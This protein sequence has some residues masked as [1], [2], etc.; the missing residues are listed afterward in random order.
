[1][2]SPSR[3]SVLAGTFATAA[4]A[5]LPAPAA[6][7]NSETRAFRLV[8]HVARIPLLPSPHPETEVWAYGGSVPGPEI[9]VRQGDEVEIQLVNRLAQ[10][11]TVHWHGLRIPNAMD[12][13]PELTQAPV[14]PGQSFTYA[15]SVP[16]AGTY[17]YHPHVLSS[18]Q[19]GH[20]LYGPLVVEEREPPQVDRDIL[21]VIDDWRLTETAAISQSFSDLHDMSH[22]GRLGN[23]ATLNGRDSREFDVR[24]GER[25]RL[26]LINTANARIF[27]LK[28]EGHNPLVIA[29]DGQPIQVHALK[30]PIVLGPGQR[31]DLILDMEGE[32]GRSYGVLDA[33]YE[34]QTY[35]YLDLVYSDQAAL[36]ES[37]LDADPSLPANSLPEPD[38][39]SA[40]RHSITIEGGAMGG[41]QAA[42]YRGEELTIR[43][44][45]RQGKVWALNGIAADGMKMDPLL[46][47][48]RDRSHIIEFRNN[49]AWP[50]P[51]HLHGHAF[52]IL[53]RNGRD[54][55]HRPWADTVILEA[56]EVVAVAFVA[57]NPGDWLLHCHVLEHHEAGM[58]CVVR[59]A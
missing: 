35:K 29:R 32:P 25:L 28:F 53:S 7:S 2:I 39:G 55:A 30:D 47:F 18:R 21:W 17:W 1:M 4:L 44:L 49:T 20:G 48:E 6:R 58:A 56:D 11:T 5:T 24:A 37:P 27:G 16:D 57:D 43:D 34:R 12:G 50:H 22:A 3:R 41:L 19:V 46:T 33:Y 54:E 52:R 40:R 13:V 38:L 36:R 51:M 31:A 23:T 59:V 10:P 8:P 42:Q 26:R 14:L 15:F 45:A 9:R